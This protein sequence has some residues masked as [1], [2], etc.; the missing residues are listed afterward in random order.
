MFPQKEAQNMAPRNLAVEYRPV[1]SIRFDPQNPRLH[2][3][4]QVRQIANS[5]K[6]FGFNVPVLVDSNLQVIAGH[7]RLLASQLLGMAEVPVI[8]LE[9]MSEH[10]RRAYMIADNQLAQNA[11]WDTKLLGEQLKIL[12]EAE[13]EFNLDAT[14]FEMCEID[15][16]IEGLAPANPSKDDPADTILKSGIESQVTQPGE[17]W[18]LDRNR[19]YCGDARYDSA[20]SKLM[21]GRSAGM[22]FTDPPY[23][24]PIDGYVAGF[25]KVHHHEFAMASGEMSSSEFVK[26]LT[27]VLSQLARNSIDGALQFICMDWRHSGELILAARSIDAEFKNLCVWVKDIAG[28]GSL[29]RSQHELVFVFKNGKGAHRNNIQLG[30]YGRYRTNVWQYRRVNSL[31]RTTDE[32]NLT[33][34]HPTIKPVEMVA[35]AILDCTARGDLVLDPFLGSGTTVIAAERTGRVCYGMELDPRYLDIIIRRWQKFTGLEAVHQGT[36]QTFAQRENQVPDAQE[37]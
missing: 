17:G 22:V 8:R 6:S 5:I 20:Y 2:S 21:E 29:Y 13:I 18:A 35:D 33:D 19:V 34:L 32:N 16:A 31:A 27:S 24:V 30:Q 12:S 25:G 14:G 7:G 37:K 11:E 15:M 3:R 1:D 9:Q 26:F 28:Q 4:K 36:G 10:Q 23:N